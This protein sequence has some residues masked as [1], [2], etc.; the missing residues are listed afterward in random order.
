MSEDYHGN[1]PVLQDW[2]DVPPNSKLSA[3]LAVP[4]A[5][6]YPFF[7]LRLAQI[8][9]DASWKYDGT[10]T[11]KQLQA[12][13]NFRIFVILLMAGVFGVFVAYFA[14]NINTLVASAIGFGAVLTLIL[15]MFYSGIRLPDAIK[16]LLVAILLILFVWLSVSP[17]LN[18]PL[19]CQ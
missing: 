17:D 11:A 2:N 18:Q 15:A 1:N 10:K 16:L 6:G 12:E 14:V 5:A 7:F 3:L 8:V 4:I 19:F 9:T 13:K